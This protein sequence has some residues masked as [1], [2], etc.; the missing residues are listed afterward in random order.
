ME[1]RRNEIM[2]IK[3]KLENTANLKKCDNKKLPAHLKD[4]TEGDHLV[5]KTQEEFNAILKQEGI[6]LEGGWVSYI[7]KQMKYKS[8]KIKYKHIAKFECSV[9]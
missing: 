7:K 4:L 2:E 5:F 3:L 1:K 6:S 8:G 9:N